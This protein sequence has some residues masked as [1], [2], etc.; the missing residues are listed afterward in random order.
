MAKS[1]AVE[2]PYE[3]MII[4]PSET[5][6]KVVDEFVEKIKKSLTETKGTVNSVQI[7]GRRRLTYPIKRQREG[8]YVYVDFIG[9]FASVR[10]L[11]NLYRVSDLVLRHLTV[12]KRKVETPEPKDVSS[13]P[14]A[15]PAVATQAQTPTPPSAG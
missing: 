9:G 14:A 3:S 2:R 15:A 4:C 8:L 1:L 7:W 12:E 5:S 10:E 11:N 6:Q 13:D